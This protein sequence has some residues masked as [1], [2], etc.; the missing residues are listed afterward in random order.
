MTTTAL[1]PSATTAT[2]PP[3]ETPAKHHPHRWR[4]RRGGIVNVWYYYESEFAFSGGRCIWRGTNGAGKSRAL[5]MLLPFLLDA[6]RRKMDATGTGKVRL[7]DLMKAG[8]DEQPNRLGYLWLELARADDN[9]CIEY[10]TSGALVR[11]SQST[12]EAKVSYFTTPLRVGIELILLDEQR[13]PLSRERLVELVGADRVTEAPETHRERIRGALFAL[14]GESGRERCNGLLQLLHTLRSPDVGNRIDEGR[15]PG[16]LSDALPPL[17]EAALDSAGEQLDALSETRTAQQR[18]DEARAHVARFL[19]VY[20]RYAA[21]ALTGVADAART[22]AADDR[23][24]QDSAQAEADRHR[25]LHDELTETRKHRARLETTESELAATIAGIKQSKEYDHVHDLDQREQQVYALGLAADR[26]LEAAGAARQHEQTAVAEADGR[27]ADIASAAA[28]AAAARREARERLDEAKAPGTLPEEVTAALG[29]PSPVTEVVRCD[30]ISDPVPLARPMP[31]S[32]TMLPAN[33]GEAVGQARAVKRAAETRSGQAAHRSSVAKDLAKQR[34]QA[35]RAE[36]RADEADSRAEKAAAEAAASSHRRDDE[37][38][39]LAAGWRRWTGDG[40][41]IAL[42][43][44]VE[45]HGTPVGALLID[46]E[47]LTGPDGDEAALAALDAAAEAAATPARESLARRAA[48]LDVAQDEADQARKALLDEQ[49]DL[50]ATHDPAPMAAPWHT[51]TPQDGVPLWQAVDFASAVTEETR[52]GVEAALHAAGLLTATVANGTLTAA[53]GQVLAAASGP[54]ASLPLSAVLVPDPAA[55]LDPAVV[56]AIL[57]RVAFGDRSH[58]VWVDE[59]GSWGNGPL[60]GR[61]HSDTARHIG[62]E[63]RAAARASRLATIDSEL[64][65]LDAADVRRKAD[66][67]AIT[68]ERDALTAHMR[69]TPRTSRLVSLRTIAVGDAHRADGAAA[70]ARTLRTKANELL[71]AWHAANA[72]HEAAC[73]ALQLPVTADELT[74][75]QHAAQAAA[76]ACDELAGRFTDMAACAEHHN[77]ALG[78]VRDTGIRRAAAED[79]AE[80]DW[81]A[82]QTADASFK[83]ARAN[84][85]LEADRVR[86]KLRTAETRYEETTGALRKARGDEVRIGGLVAAA[87]RDAQHAQDNAD[88]AR[89]E[90]RSTTAELLRVARLPGVAVAAITEGKTFEV[91]MSEVTAATVETAARSLASAVD[92][93]GGVADENTLIRAQQSLERDLSGT[94]DV[95]ASINGGVRIVELADAAGRWPLADAAAELTRRADEGRLALSERERRVFTDFVLGG[96]A[97]ELRRRLGQARQLIDAVNASLATI[98]TSHGIGV[99]VRWNL[100]EQADSPIARIRELVLIADKVRRGEQTAELTELVRSQVNLAFAEDETAGYA[101]HL[102]AA[103][104]YRNWHD[105]EVIILGP[106]PGQERRMSRRAKLSQ[107]EIRFVSYVTLFA[108][109]DAYL[110]GL[111]DTTWALRLILLDDAFAKVDNPTIAEMIGLLVR[112]DIDFAMTGHALWGCY[113]QVP[114]LDVYEVRR[115][116]GSAAVTT[117]VHWDGRT[118]HLRAAR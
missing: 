38:V 29:S 56:A 106:A 11:F 24:A 60:T 98:R 84:V 37:A 94:F 43:G 118:R 62:A 31:A 99:R 8:G 96:V 40:R 108:A 35:D 52:A 91:T 116:D 75:V 111:P 93:R 110:S 18:L 27:A 61:H 49:A 34:S 65:A 89:A 21:G 71:A 48:D 1:R 28:K 67:Q 78:R 22:A 54:E 39:A 9:G 85:G 5:E 23:A 45:W 90:L 12:A 83:A 20:R 41:T 3:A 59:D 55:P 57:D 92:R 76:R 64:S 81:H 87:E 50:R 77:A 97:E 16:I 46:V 68:E 101:T 95:L 88:K 113:P 2:E 7:E 66:G 42:L 44:A 47:T 15:L 33:P 53:D 36:E 114:A 70:E 103:L 58:P 10:F 104:D 17:S 69:T 102:K 19:D 25:G 79:A 13:M 26:S 73:A 105:V 112:L 63:A 4:L 32:A 80:R 117:H 6:D 86:A 109:V 115:R 51:S 82:W 107:G 72:A 14:T 74:S 100:V 30:Q